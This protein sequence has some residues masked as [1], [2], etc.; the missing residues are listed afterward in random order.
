MAGTVV[1][2]KQSAEE[3]FI[4]FRSCAIEEI[5]TKVMAEA[6]AF[7][8]SSVFIAN[9]EQIE[10][11]KEREKMLRDLAKQQ[12]LELADKSA[13]VLTKEL[14]AIIQKEKQLKDPFREKKSVTFRIAINGAKDDDLASEGGGS[15]YELSSNGS[16]RRGKI[17]VV[18][19]TEDAE[20]LPDLTKPSSLSKAQRNS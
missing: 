2:K 4:R 6:E 15:N 13:V 18:N 17:I 5:K 1:E 14:K 20:D 7:K 3:S 9:K 19:P 8:D 11:A 16:N 12:S 10:R